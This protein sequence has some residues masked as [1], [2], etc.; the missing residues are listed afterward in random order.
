MVLVLTDER[1]FMGRVVEHIGK[2]KVGDGV[3]EKEM[4]EK[5]LVLQ[6]QPAQKEKPI[7]SADYW[8]GFTF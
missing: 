4:G 2:P 6:M 1:L 7:I 8:T 3:Q 5:K